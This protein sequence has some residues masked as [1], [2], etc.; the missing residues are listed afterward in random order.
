M[1]TAPL[2]DAAALDVTLRIGAP[3]DG[4]GVVLRLDGAWR[5]GLRLVRLAPQDEIG[6][7]GLT[8]E[9]DQ[10]IVPARF[11]GDR[12]E[13][14]AGNTAVVR[15]VA[16]PG[17]VGRH[18]L[19]GRLQPDHATFDGRV[20]LRPDVDA[21]PIAVRY[22]VPDAWQVASPHRRE[23]DRWVVDEVPRWAAAEALHT[24]CIAAGDLSVDAFRVG[25]TPVEV[26]TWNGFPQDRTAALRDGTR[27]MA[28][29][30]HET[31]GFDTGVP[32]VLVFVP[33]PD[34]HGV[35]GGAW[36]T[37]ACYE[38]TAA[39]REW[40]LL[41][42]RFAH[43]MNKY[44]PAGVM[45]RD[46]RDRW[47][48]EAF[49][50]WVEIAS[51]EAVGLD[52]T[53]TAFLDL[54][55]KYLTA[56]WRRPSVD[57]ALA[58]EPDRTGDD[59]EFL[60]YVKGP[61]VVRELATA[62]EAHGVRLTD[63]VRGWS[64]RGGRYD[65]R[66]DVLAVAPEVADLFARSVD[67][68]G[69]LVPLDLAGPG[70]PGEPA[71]LLDGEPL[72]A[73]HV[74]ALLASGDVARFSELMPL[75][76][77]DEAQRRALAR[78]GSE[79]STRDQLDAIDPRVSVDVR[80][81]HRAIPVAQPT[82]GCTTAKPPLAVP[83]DTPSGRALAQARG[84]E[85]R[86]GPDAP[87]VLHVRLTSTE[88]EAESRPS[89]LAVWRRSG[90]RVTIEFSSP[91]P[92][93]WFELLDGERVLARK[94]VDTQPGWRRAWVSW[95]ADELASEGARLVRVGAGARVLAERVVWIAP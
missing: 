58:D 10:R 8:A 47:F 50:S 16:R 11:D 78:T 1:G 69:L 49:A 38:G 79:I 74:A 52:T 67:D 59:A 28:T 21:W 23:G 54:Y 25:H 51:T 70:E 48:V 92:T 37:G 88:R 60:H 93:I 26:W 32:F 64:Q 76:S 90:L 41:G 29:W 80:R 31:V 71:A 85:G 53:G 24:A 13:L 61:L 34:E 40:Q 19:Q 55:R 72:G 77:T 22:E 83:A 4:V 20:I 62:L 89:A 17:G 5:D 12:L 9:V 2:G 18:G 82:G 84:L 95:E 94:D 75:L 7:D 63:L 27:R 56:R 86:L 68:V 45:P 39:T 42:H 87:D 91:P 44:P 30:F 46:A 73:H 43:P 6:I 33:R 57:A 15:Y 66:A 14:P 81:A 36:A 65:L 35:F 3:D